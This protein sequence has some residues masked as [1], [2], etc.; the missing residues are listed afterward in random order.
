MKGRLSGLFR[1]CAIYGVA[2][3]LAVPLIVYRHQISLIPPEATH[4]EI[5]CNMAVSWVTVVA[6]TSCVWAVVILML[7]LARFTRERAPVRPVS[8]S[9]R[10][11]RRRAF[12]SFS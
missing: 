10:P 12:L 3:L 6:G 9:S 11:P 8:I 4:P 2:G 5:A 7:G 1:A